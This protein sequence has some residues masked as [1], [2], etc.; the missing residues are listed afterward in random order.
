[1]KALVYQGPGKLQLEERPVPVPGIDEVLIKVKAVSI[2]GSDLGAYRLPEI[3][4]RWNPPIV[5]GHEFSGE[6]AG[7]GEGVTNFN[8]AQPVTVN[9]I[10]YCGHCYYCSRGIVNLCPN[11][12]SLGTSIGGIR[13][14]GALQ[15]YLTVRASAVY[16]LLPGISFVQ[17]ALVEP[18]SVSLC[19]A[20]LGEIK[21]D[22]RV[23]L[24]GVGPIGLMILK[25]LKTDPTRL[26]F[27]SDISQSRLDMAKRFGADILIDGRDDVLSETK[28]LTNG[29]GV[30][31]VVVAAGVPGVLPLAMQ[32][33]RNG[34]CV[35]LVALMHHKVEID[36]L[37]IVARQL[38]IC[39]SYMFTTE[40]QDVIQM[41]ADKQI[42]V[43]E[44]ITSV[45]RLDEGVEVFSELT[46][47]DSSEVKVIL[48]TD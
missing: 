32:M 23:S 34:G 10:L 37:Q 1:M 31:R 19:A 12:Y 36:P 18:L 22:E 30:D 47:P 16:P 26:V 2:C 48:T 44:M 21:P 7:L 4:D 42:N 17:G 9:P 5:L 38:S 15:E 45:H 6:I 13:H 41:L 43:D 24:I 3:S 25:F 40:F 20:R 14:D 33:V 29:I 35:D 28:T 27:V 8:I 46:K 39:G 11:R